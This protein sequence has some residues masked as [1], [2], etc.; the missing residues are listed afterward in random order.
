MI[1]ACRLRISR[2]RRINMQ[3][4]DHGNLARLAQDIL[5]RRSARVRHPH[6]PMRCQCRTTADGAQRHVLRTLAFRIVGCVG[7]ALAAAVGAAD[8]DG[9]GGEAGDYDGCVMV[10]IGR[11]KTDVLSVI[12]VLTHRA[13]NHTPKRQP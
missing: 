5:L 1:I 11:A 9:E 3:C 2:I 12:V 10:R 13:F 7:V 4:P 8:G 6:G